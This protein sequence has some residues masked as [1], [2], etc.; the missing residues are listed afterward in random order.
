MALRLRE[1]LNEVL[2]SHLA[3]CEKRRLYRFAVASACNG[4]NDGWQCASCGQKT[5]VGKEPPDD[6]STFAESVTDSCQDLAAFASW[7]MDI[8]EDHRRGLPVPLRNAARNLV[9]HRGFKVHHVPK[10]K[11]QRVTTQITVALDQ[12]KQSV[13][14]SQQ[15]DSSS[16][17]VL[18]SIAV[19][20]SDTITDDSNVGSGLARGCGSD[21]YSS[22][23]QQHECDKVTDSW[24]H[25]CASGRYA[26][27]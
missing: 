20:A 14:E 15:L 3:E 17:E 5:A 2:A 24:H 9:R 16:E 12:R 22:L 4:T 8:L 7:L 18:E 1:V 26:Q 21:S 6:Q 11:C 10:G 23:T 27:Q 19:E 13:A 25:R